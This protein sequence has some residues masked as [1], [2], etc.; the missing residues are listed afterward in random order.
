VKS[1]SIW[2]QFK[3]LL[4]TLFAVYILTLA[5]LCVFAILSLQTEIPISYFTRD[6]SAIMGAPFFIGLFS[7][8]GI[9]FWCSSAAICLFTFAVLR[10]DFD[11]RELS[12]FFLFSG[13]ITSILLLDDLFL[14]HEEVCLKYLHI[15]EEVVLPDVDLVY[16]D[17]AFKSDQRYNVIFQE[18]DGTK[19]GAQTKAFEDI[20]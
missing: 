13:L 15:P 1:K 2:C 20:P 7:N 3:A 10:K 19:S 11:N 9:L 5:V 4:P 6:P 18:K 14:F 8:V 12:S 16:L 17:P